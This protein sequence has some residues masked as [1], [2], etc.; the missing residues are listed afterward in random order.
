MIPHHVNLRD[1]AIA[2]ALIEFLKEI[3]PDNKIVYN[4]EKYDNYIH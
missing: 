4:L 1:Q 2:L 3:F